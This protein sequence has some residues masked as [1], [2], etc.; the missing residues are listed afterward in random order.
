MAKFKAICSECGMAI[1]VSPAMYKHYIEQYTVQ[2]AKEG[3][4]G[5]TYW[6]TVGRAFE[7][8]KRITVKLDSL[9][10]HSSWDGRLFLYRVR[11]RDERSST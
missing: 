5:I 7:D 4:D 1:K 10:I 6:P 3:K 9:P 11:S 2:Y 8:D